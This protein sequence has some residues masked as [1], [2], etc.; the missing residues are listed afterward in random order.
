[1]LQLASKHRQHREEAD[2]ILTGFSQKEEKTQKHPQGLR[3]QLT[4]QD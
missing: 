1:M 3:I 2:P 4:S